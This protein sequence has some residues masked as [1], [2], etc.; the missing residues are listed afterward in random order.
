MSFLEILL[1]Q[2]KK[3]A[4]KQFMETHIGNLHLTDFSLHS[5][6][7]LLFR[8]GQEDVFSSF[9]VDVLPNT[10]LLSLPVPQY[11]EV[12]TA[13]NTLDLDFDDAYQYCVAKSS[14]LT[15]VTMDRDFEFVSDV[16]VLFL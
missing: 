14:G 10:T 7:V 15:I 16:D 5:M 13:K 4:C 8:Y 2:T 6:G 1:G 3:D 12:V 9:L 11:R